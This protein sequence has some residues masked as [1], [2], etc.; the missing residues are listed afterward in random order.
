MNVIT[1][2]VVKSKDELIIENDAKNDREYWTI[3]HAADTT[4][5]SHGYFRYI[6]K[7]PPQIA[8][9]LIDDY[10]S[11]KGKLLDP[12]V[13]GG[14][15]LIEAVLR[16]IRCEGWDINPISLLISR[17]VSQHVDASLYREAG[18][19]LIDGLSII[20]G[21][22]SLFRQKDKSWIKKGLNLQYC[23]EYFD[24]KTKEELE[25]AL[26]TTD[27]IARKD[28][29]V[30]ELIL[31][32]I[33]S[34]LRQISFA[35]VKKMNL[36]LDFNKKT[37][38][39]L[40]KEFTQKFRKIIKINEELPDNFERG[41]AQVHERSAVNWESTDKF[42]MIFIHPPYLTN[43]AFSESTQLQLAILNISHKEIWKKE[44]RCRGSFLHEPNGLKKYLISWAKIITAAAQALSK[45]GILATVVGDGQIEHVRVPVGAITIEFGS[46]AGLKV[47]KNA[48]HILNNN[49]GQTQSKK[50]KGQHVIIFKKL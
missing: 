49:T 36:E 4:Y 43:T 24:E 6:G 35:N 25:Y 40:Y 34:C 46:D 50:M 20:N 19:Q 8:S 16:G 31:L 9:K 42:G 15:V 26:Q 33:L 13:G 11:G 29:A 7:F 14:T 38:T 21:D 32:T 41:L 3:P 27:L 45:G 2:R 37:K 23:S 47:V 1:N 12:M 28:N 30:S 39:S 10:Y 44:L 18:E 48:F 5:F 17:C 22:G